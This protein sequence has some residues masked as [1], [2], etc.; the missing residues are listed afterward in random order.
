MKL[1][2]I[3]INNLLRR[4][5]KLLFVLLGLI[6]GIGT[7]VS[8]YSVVDA[9]KLEMTRQASEF[10]VNV[11]ITPDAGGLAFSYGGITLPEIMYDVEQL[12][13][14]DVT[15][16]AS[17]SSKEMIKI[18][19]PKL[20][21]LAKLENHKKAMVVG[22]NLQE[23]FTIKPWLRL[24]N[25]NEAEADNDIKANAEEGDKNMSF[26]SLDLSRQELALLS[27]NDNQVIVGSMS[28]ASLGL[29]EGSVLQLEG[30]EFEVYGILAESGNGEDNQIYMSLTVAQE[31][32]NRPDEITVIEMAVDYSLSSEEKLLSELEAAL[33]H[34]QITSMRQET[35]RRDEM[36][37]RLVRF[38]MT[39]S[40]LVLLIGM[41]VVGLTMFSSVRERTREIGVFRALGFRK[42]D[43]AKLIL[44]EGLLISI[45][46]GILGYLF[47]ML[48]AN[49]SGELLVGRE[50]VVQW[51]FST[52]VLAVGLAIFMGLISS[53]Y[54]AYSAANQDPV[55]ALRFF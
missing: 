9:M 47:G 39:I 27:L 23:E 15:T 44:L 52:I 10:G 42:L 41:L 13:N 3:S 38:G 1:Y 32:L 30:K 35:L 25:D 17:V 46:G 40:V 50:I 14:E 16:V 18:I 5:L 24:K 55:E 37:T 43:I 28:A 20:M 49:Y 31:L 7:I 26:Q 11:V 12:T 8:V 33:P 6:I 34:T 45:G 21:G 22:A 2:N 29:T 48:V 36:L 19:S 54:P 53:L 51:H 4:K